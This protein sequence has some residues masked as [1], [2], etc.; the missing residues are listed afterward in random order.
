MDQDD[1]NELAFRSIVEDEKL[2]IMKE[3]L[4]LMPV[5]ESGRSAAP[6]C[7]VGHSFLLWIWVQARS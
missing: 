4:M 5:D 3:A 7:W 6:D 1:F 2:M